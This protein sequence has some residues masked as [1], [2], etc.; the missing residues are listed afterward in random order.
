MA[1]GKLEQKLRRIQDLYIEDGLSR[2]D[3]FSMRE[4]YAGEKAMTEHKLDETRS[5]NTGLKK[6]IETAVGLLSNIGNI[7][8][9]ADLPDKR[10]IISSIFPEN[11]FFDGTKCRTPRINEVLRLILL[12]DNKKH[13][14][15]SGQISEFLDLSAKGGG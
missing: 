14:N 3:Y 5:V 7:Y 4:R 2:E 9:N 12:I 15:E 6:S 1:L 11:L 10:K 8:K 13:Q